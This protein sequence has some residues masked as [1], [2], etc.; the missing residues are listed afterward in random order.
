V[1]RWL[2]VLAFAAVLTA[3]GD[4]GG[5]DMSPSAVSRLDAAVTDVRTAVE[6]DDLD[7]ARA[8]LTSLRTTVAA[9][10]VSNAITADR[11]LA[12]NEAIT[13]VEAEIAARA[14]PVTAAPTSTTRVATTSTTTTAAP[15]GNDKKR[16]R[17]D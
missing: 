15:N 13:R 14:T 17:D 1:R 9:L 12:I 10:A 2:A 6:A 8:Q 4:D 11:A 16:D 3:C 5:A 7:G